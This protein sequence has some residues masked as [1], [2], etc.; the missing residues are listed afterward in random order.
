[1]DWPF[2]Q[3]RI[4]PT[5]L[6]TQIDRL[7]L[8]YGQEPY[9]AFICQTLRYVERNVSLCNLVDTQ[10]L[11]DAAKKEVLSPKD[12]TL[13]AKWRLASIADVKGHAKALFGPF[14]NPRFEIKWNVPDDA[15][16]EENTW[17]CP[18]WI[19]LADIELVDLVRLIRSH[20]NA[21][22]QMYLWLVRY[23]SRVW[24]RP[25]PAGLSLS[26]DTKGIVY[27]PSLVGS[28]LCPSHP[29]APQP[30]VPVDESRHITPTTAQIAKKI[31]LMHTAFNTSTCRHGTRVDQKEGKREKTRGRGKK[32]EVDLPGAPHPCRPTWSTFHKL[33]VGQ[34]IEKPGKIV[35]HTL[36]LVTWLVH[37]AF[38]NFGDKHFDMDTLLETQCSPNKQLLIETLSERTEKHTTSADK[39]FRVHRKF[40]MGKGVDTCLVSHI[41][42]DQFTLP[43]YK[44]C[45]GQTMRAIA[46]ATELKSILKAFGIESC[47]QLKCRKPAL[48]PDILL[49][50]FWPGQLVELK[51]AT[52][53]GGGTEYFLIT[54]DDGDAA[55]FGVS[56]T[57]D[58]GAVKTL[59]G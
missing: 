43:F 24:V 21:N 58:R 59:A 17:Q 14:C 45:H 6:P 13:A 15:D 48:S 42:L 20:F 22:W 9:S 31:K 50:Q 46:S 56:L 34:W 7:R 47:E 3:I 27:A 53:S 37:R 52:Y 18:Y 2:G 41:F 25:A 23:A 38:W 36:R 4:A 44:M 55:Y 5:R 28:V 30:F 49:H 11:Y 35:S 39:L 19:D 29:D 26:E 16:N 12:V 1:M 54:H 57:T 10:W 33:F 32:S 8:I 51:L 40:V